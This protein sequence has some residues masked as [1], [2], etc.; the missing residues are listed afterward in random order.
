[1]AGRHRAP[2]DPEAKKLER[3]IM[4]QRREAMKRER[5][6]RGPEPANWWM[7]K[8]SIFALVFSAALGVFA[9]FTD[10]PLMWVA[11][12]Q[13]LIYLA[14][15]I[16]EIHAHLRYRAANNPGKTPH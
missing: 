16:R 10:P 4:K 14:G 2:Y 5:E 1:M 3:E 13:A 15:L 6:A 11:G 7:V 8:L 12:L 9:W